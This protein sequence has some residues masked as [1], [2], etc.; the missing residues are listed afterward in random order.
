MDYLH[1][2]FAPFLQDSYGVV[3][4]HEHVLRILADTMRISLAEADELRRRMEK[5]AEQIEGEFRERTARNT[6]EDNN[7]IFSDADIDRLWKALR[8]FGSFGFCK[9]HGAAF[10]L[11]TYQSAWLKTH[12]PVEFLT[13]I[14][15]HDPGMYPRLLLMAEARRMLIP[16]LGIDINAS[17]AWLPH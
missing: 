12:Y 14:F 17:D 13:A 7:R 2:R 5:D 3:L 10:A 9:A 1:P 11:P 6:D 15:E 8:S 4:Y 16:L